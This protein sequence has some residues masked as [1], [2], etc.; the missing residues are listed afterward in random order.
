MPNNDLND[1]D[2]YKFDDLDLLASEPDDSIPLEPEAEQ[3]D[4]PKRSF[5]FELTP[6]IRNGLIA[7][8]FLLLVIF[9]YEFIV[10]MLSGK[11]NVA[12][13][14]ITPV[15]APKSFT[16]AA[17]PAVAIQPQPIVSSNTSLNSQ[18]LP[19]LSAITQEQQNLNSSVST[20]GGQLNSL[21]SNL[22]AM[23]TQ[24][25]QLNA[26]MST[27][28]DRI[29]EQ[30]DQLHSLQQ[31]R[32][33][34]KQ[35]KLKHKSKALS[36]VYALQAVIPGRA[37]LIADNGSNLTVREGTLIDGYGVVKLIDAQRGRVVT[38]SGRVI[39][40]SQADS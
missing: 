19:Q 33:V 21:S 16:P 40:F 20:M 6:T 17:T 4:P 7:V 10:A 35:Q 14:E 29:A 27:L 1:H 11:K 13:Q 32:A 37:W 28:N 22:D 15:I 39:G 34:A 25:K 8:G 9:S 31:Q 38:S 23:M 3:P 12:S 2:E 24:V 30:A 5:S 18:V 26:T 36:T